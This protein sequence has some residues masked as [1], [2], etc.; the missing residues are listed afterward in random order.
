M[1]KRNTEKFY[2]IKCST[3]AKMLNGFNAAESVY[4]W[5]GQ[6]VGQ[7]EFKVGPSTDRFNDTESIYSMVSD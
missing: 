2:R 4:D 1:A 6:N 3:L 7:E 5:K